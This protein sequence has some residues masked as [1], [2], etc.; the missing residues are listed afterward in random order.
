M[1][2]AI[3][4]AVIVVTMRVPHLSLV[5]AQMTSR[6]L[7]RKPDPTESWKHQHT[8]AFVTPFTRGVQRNI[9]EPDIRKV[10]LAAIVDRV[11]RPLRSD[12]SIAA[13]A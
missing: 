8:V 1:R 13:A 4:C 3:S 7:R 5:C 6:P 11:T 10:R 12:R 9:N 2:P